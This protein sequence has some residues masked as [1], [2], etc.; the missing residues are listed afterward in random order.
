VLAGV[1]SFVMSVEITPAGKRGSK[2]P[3]AAIAMMGVMPGLYR[4]LG[5]R[6]MGPTLVLT[7]IGAKSGQ[8]RDAH[9]T[10]FPEGDGW[11]VVASK[12][13][14]ATHPAWF[15]NM[16][17]HP[18]QVW[19]Q[20]GKRKLRVEPATLKGAARGT[21]WKRIVAEFSNYAEYEEKTD[22]EIPVIRLTPVE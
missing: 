10:A 16:A 1:F 13:G 17:R 22:R 4:L 7:T 2:L 15:V 21:A 18:D 3:R 8:K 5:G 20:V 14:D 9:L 12:G 6:A 11:L 19:V